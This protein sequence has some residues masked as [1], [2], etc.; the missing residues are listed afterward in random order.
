MKRHLLLGRKA[1]TKV[2]SLLTSGGITLLTQICR[3]KT[4]FP[5]SHIWMWELGHKKSWALKDDAFKLWCWWR[6]LRVPWTAR[7][8]NQSI[9]PE[10]SL[11]GLVLKLQLQYFGHL[12]WRAIWESSQAVMRQIKGS[13]C[14]K[15][16]GDHSCLP[17]V[18]CKCVSVK[19]KDYKIS[20][21]SFLRINW[22]YR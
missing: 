15:K 21:L 12:R 20:N 11:K 10:Y 19:N 8:L 7:Q 13:T 14:A 1:M 18:R 2:A 3:V 16:I 9:N 5:S 6:L 22:Q 4:G 17:F